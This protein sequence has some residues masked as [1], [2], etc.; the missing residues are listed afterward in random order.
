MGT[1]A[2]NSA[3][4]YSGRTVPKKPSQPAID[5][6][7]LMAM[8]VTALAEGKKQYKLAD[9]ALDALVDQLRVGQVIELPKTFKIPEDLRGKKFAIADKFAKRNSI[10][11]GLSARRFEVEEVTNP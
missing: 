8:H 6:Y 1:L 3:R 2:V 7:T 5:A 11:V 9:A 4:K 10:G